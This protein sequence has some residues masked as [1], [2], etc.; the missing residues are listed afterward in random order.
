V[1]DTGSPELAVE[2]ARAIQRLR[3]RIRVESGL[4]ASPWSRGQLLALDR[5]VAGPPMTTSDLAAAEFVRPQSMAATLAPLEEA[6]LVTR[7]RDPD[8]RRRLFVVPTDAGRDLL[9]SVQEQRDEW[10]ARAI[11]NELDDEELA[12]LPALVRLLDRL[13]DSEVRFVTRSKN[14]L[15]V[16]R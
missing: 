9:R 10:L 5:V 16:A 3:A 14:P 15:Q 12:A 6:G 4:G 8:D 2:L 13:T 7:R 1:N 11:E